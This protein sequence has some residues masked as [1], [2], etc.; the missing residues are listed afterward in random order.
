MNKHA[1]T[2]V[3]A[4]AAAI[5][6][7][8][9]TGALA[10][11]SPGPKPPYLTRE[12]NG[13]YH[14]Y[15]RRVTADAGQSVSASNP[16][17]GAW[18]LL[19]RHVYSKIQAWNADQTLLAVMNADCGTNG[20]ASC[21]VSSLFL[22]ANKAGDTYRVVYAK[23]RPNANA[24]NPDGEERWHP[25]NPDL[26][27]YLGRNSDGALA[28]GS[29]NV[30]TD[31]VLVY[32]TFPQYARVQMGPWEGNLSNDGNVVAI[33][34]TKPCGQV[35][36]FAYNLQTDTVYPEIDLTGVT[37]DWASISPSG[38]FIV[39]NGCWDS[40]VNCAGVATAG[41]RTLIKPIDNVGKSVGWNEF[42]RPS[43]FDLA[44]D[45]D[46]SDVAV[47]V[48]KWATSLGG[49]AGEE[50]LVIKRSL[51]TS[52]VTR[53]T[54]GGYA[55]HT[56]TRNLQRPGWAYV[57]YGC[58][59]CGTNWL[60]YR[61]EL[62]AVPLDGSGAVVRWINFNSI[63]GDLNYWDQPQ[64][65]PSPDGNRAIWAST[66]GIGHAAVANPPNKVDGYVAEY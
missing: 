21:A 44:L 22:D 62:L 7:Q 14:R 61:D 58:L 42:G 55:S 51:T 38:K 26:R 50:G 12:V 3:G 24:G 57:S 5:G 17:L 11:S 23:T 13:T 46:G 41:D 15:F 34:G 54:S 18:G 48:S 10:Q 35:V 65:S 64:A 60:P 27:I 49:P 39:I 28:I 6:L 8:V 31:A 19:T 43:H 2:L 33:V 1:R 40:A 4:M 32:R 66:W 52:A 20:S 63:V 45:A 56:S 30:R 59:D 29:W 25:T 37:L 36:V 16:Q 53:L 9:A 47:G